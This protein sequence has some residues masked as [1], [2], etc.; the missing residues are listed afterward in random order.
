[1]DFRHFCHN[2]RSVMNRELF[3]KYLDLRD[4]TLFLQIGKE[5]AA[6]AFFDFIVLFLDRESIV[7][8]QKGT[9]TIDRQREKQRDGH[10]I[11]KWQSC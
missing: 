5:I 6:N 1:M 7:S 3:S 10:S 4:F 11:Q 9:T 2:Y 8:I